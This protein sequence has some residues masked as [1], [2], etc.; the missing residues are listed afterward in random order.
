MLKTLQF[1]LIAKA[2]ILQ[3]QNP[4]L[5]KLGDKGNQWDKIILHKLRTGFNVFNEELLML[6][7]W[8][9]FTRRKN[10][11]GWIYIFLYFYLFIFIYVSLFLLDIKSEKREGSW[12]LL[13]YRQQYTDNSIQI[14]DN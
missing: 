13:V 12:K 4:F 5:T 9:L 7:L 10:L 8:D 11:T 6:L 1:P 14:T 3:F 2:V